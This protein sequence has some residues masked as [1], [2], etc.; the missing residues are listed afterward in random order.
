MMNKI[1]ES[2]IALSSNTAMKGSVYVFA[3][4]MIANV[5]AYLYHLIVGKILGPEGYGELSSLISLLYIFGVANQVIQ[6][7]LV[8][9]FSIKKAS[10]SVGQARYLF[11]KSTKFLL[12]IL[13]ITGILFSGASGIIADFLHLPQWHFIVLVFFILAFST[14]STVNNSVLQGFQLFLWFGVFSALSIVLRLILSIPLAYYGVGPTLVASIIA[15]GIAYFL[16]FLPIRFLFQKEREPFSLKK[17]GAL[18]YSIPTLLSII[19]ITSLYST[20]IIL[21]KHFFQ[22][23]DAGIYA[24]VAVLGKIIFYASSAIALVAF[25]MISENT[26]KKVS[27]EKVI[28]F[29]FLAVLICSVGITILYFLVPSFITSLLFGPAYASV[30]SYLGLFA[31]FIGCF[32]VAYLSIMV[33]LALG[34]TGVWVFPMAAALLQA[35]CICLFHVK[36]MDV[37]YL[38]LC[39]SVFLGI[40]LVLFILSKR[41]R[42][43]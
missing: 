43:I 37:I 34:F 22:A 29:S 2:I 18:S 13:F 35:I 27:S 6:T 40:S 30:S 11:E 16:S 14:L 12:I 41:K 5:C 23:H 26:E 20:D 39:I 10:S 21:V 9:Y 17:L 25:P 28:R 36:L 19:G 3:G 31:V 4:T 32:S 38:N 24:A 42:R 1:K 7:V 8:K 33:S 15:V